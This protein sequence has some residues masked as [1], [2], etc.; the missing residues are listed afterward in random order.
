VAPK[1]KLQKN[2]NNE[3]LELSKEERK[4]EKKT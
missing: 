3:G 1:K 2:R 4:K